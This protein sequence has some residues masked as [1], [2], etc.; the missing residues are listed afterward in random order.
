MIDSTLRQSSLVALAA[1]LHDLGKFAERAGAF[2]GDP[3]LDANLQLYSPYHEQGRWFS[4]RHA[5]HT[6]LAFDLIEKHLPDLLHG[7]VSPFSGRVTSADADAIDA[8]DSLV[9]ASAAHH[10]PV[11]FLQWVIATADRVASG[12]ER[13]EFDR[14]NQAKE[15]RADGL[16]HFTARLLTLFEQVRLDA[17]R[18][19]ATRDA[20]GWRYPLDPLSPESIFPRPA[21]QCEHRDKSRARAEYRALWDHFIDRLERIPASHRRSLPLWLDHFD[22]LWL[23]CTHSIPS[24]TAFGTRPEVSLYDHS[25]TTAALAVALWRWHAAEGQTDQAAADRLRAR[26]DFDTAKFLLV[27]GDFFGIQDFVFASGGETQRHAA[28]LL[29]GRSF[30][31]SLYCELAALHVLEALQLPPV[32]QILNAAGKFVIVAPDTAEIRSALADVRARFDAWFMERTFGLAS[33]GLAWE[34]ASCSDFLVS[35]DRGTD[36][37]RFER[38]TERLRQSLDRAK[39]QRLALAT[40]GAHVFDA[41]FVHGVCAW[42]GL[43]PADRVESQTGRASCA[44]SRDQIAIGG[45]LIRHGRLLVVNA[46]A[47]EQLREGSALSLLEMDVF[48]YV[49]GFAASEEASGRYGP[50]VQSGALRRCWDF[51]A[52][53]TTPGDSDGLFSGYARRFISGYVPRASDT[54]LRFPERYAPAHLDA[55]ALPASGEVKPLD[56]LACEDRTM[57]DRGR[58]IGVAALGILKGDI[59]DLG[60]I[61]R[62]GL[63]RQSFAKWASLSRQV[64]GFFSIALPQLLATEFPN[65]YTVFA[66]GDDFFLIGPWRSMQ[67]L[68]ERMHAEFSRYVA[69]NPELH[70]SAGIVTQ[71]AG[72][73]I[74]SLAALADEALGAAKSAPGKNALSCFGEVMPWSAWPEI[75][76][77]LSRLDDLRS[78]LGLT[79]GFVYG[80]LQFVEMAARERE[81]P[82]AA[83]WRA[84]LAYRTRR[85]VDDRLR[86]L[87]ALAR[88]RRRVSVVS[89]I[90]ANGIQALGARYR[91]VLYNHLYQFRNS[92]GGRA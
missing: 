64:H 19:A 66:G 60:E 27:Q 52:P 55:G 74:G 18:N 8:T 73:P 47:R 61:F 45:S 89:D 50:L 31:V 54:D 56:L 69:G 7:D 13:E 65:V 16:N 36:Q 10:K 83:I 58:W 53:D 75:E 78:E 87:D 20:L 5:A 32:S 85:F 2:D 17:P 48:G 44:L 46:D 26:S 12:F 1:F 62:V 68:G 70:F 49:V 84:R 6:A 39:H 30:Q 9:N 41:P 11:T 21:A 76:R 34:P 3:R 88:A 25:K 71:K 33:V 15:D 35:Q 59:D 86:T 63:T 14:Y 57:D 81:H 4:H 29:R 38:L 91:I 43:L 92:H 77:A 22:S 67:R 51:S 42:N 28:K 24:A 72:T 79:T 90:G 37:T 23:T 82:E 80:L 40:R